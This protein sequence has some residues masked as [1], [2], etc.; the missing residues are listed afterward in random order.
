[1]EYGKSKYIKRKG[2]ES[3]ESV[4]IK[5]KGSS[6]GSKYVKSDD[7]GEK[8]LSGSARYLEMLE[9]EQAKKAAF[10]KLESGVTEEPEIEV[11]EAVETE[12]EEKKTS[13]TKLSGSDASSETG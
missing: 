1:M 8:T 10:E 12:N 6:S 9:R 4:Y 5:K 13:Y 2:A 7:D 3:E 11:E